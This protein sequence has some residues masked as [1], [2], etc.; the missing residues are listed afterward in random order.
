MRARLVSAAARALDLAEAFGEPAQVADVELLVREAQHAVPA[1]R[2]QDLGELRA[3]R[4][5]VDVDAM[6]GR[7]EHRAG[8]FN[9][10][11]ALAPR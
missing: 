2:Q 11:H 4:S 10:Q 7:A 5:R 9:V 6:N 3:R 1:E 8:R